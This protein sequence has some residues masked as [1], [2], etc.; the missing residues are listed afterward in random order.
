MIL[1]LDDDP[2][3]YQH[4]RHLLGD[5]VELVIACCPA[6]VA[7]HL[8][9]ARAVLLDYDLDSGEPCPGCLSSYGMWRGVSKALHYVPAI[10]ARS[11]PVV[12]TSASGP[13]NIRRLLG[14]LTEYGVVHRRHSAIESDPEVRWI[15]ALWA[16]GAL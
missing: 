12:V 5:R 13:E 2:D 10:A 6:C 11:I 14:A 3:R 8:P 16:M 4:L 15:G 9:R 1:A 7:E